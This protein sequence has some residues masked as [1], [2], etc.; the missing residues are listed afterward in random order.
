MPGKEEEKR[1]RRKRKDV[2]IKSN[3][4]HLAGGEKGVFTPFYTRRTDVK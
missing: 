3:Y 1:R 2:L 4:P